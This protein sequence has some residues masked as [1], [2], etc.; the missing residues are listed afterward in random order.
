MHGWALIFLE[1]IPTSCL[2]WLLQMYRKLSVG[3]VLNAEG[4]AHDDVEW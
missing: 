1:F 4:E 3:R 2:V